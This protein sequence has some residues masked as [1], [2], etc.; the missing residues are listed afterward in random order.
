MI[1]LL[2]GWLVKRGMDSD[3]ARPIAWA[4]AIFGA[5][6]ALIAAVALWIRLHDR[7]VV[8]KDRALIEAAAQSAGRAADARAADARDA[9]RARAA[10]EADQLR[11]VT[12]NAPQASLDDARRAYYR[13][14]RIQQQARDSGGSPAAC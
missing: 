2:A 7:A 12:N 8:S 1:S 5:A 3:A 14:L 11:K 9:D 10:A 6:I 13:C 4:V